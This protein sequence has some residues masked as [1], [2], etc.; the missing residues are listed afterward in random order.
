MSWLLYDSQLMEF[1]NA[2]HECRLF[3][4]LMLLAKHALNVRVMHINILLHVYSDHA[5][6]IF[7][8]IVCCSFYDDK[9]S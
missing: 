8:D 9:F 1:S 6:C 2:I 5:T 4:I 7:A 3:P